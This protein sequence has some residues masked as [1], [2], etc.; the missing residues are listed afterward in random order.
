[1]ITVECTFL[2]LSLVKLVYRCG[3]DHL[4]LALTPDILFLQIFEEYEAMER[5]SQAVQN[6]QLPGVSDEQ[7]SE[8]QMGQ[9]E[10]DQELDQPVKK[11]ASTQWEE[12]VIDPSNFMRRSIACQ[13]NIKLKS[14]SVGIVVKPKTKNQTSNCRIKE[15]PE[16]PVT[17]CSSY[18]SSTPAKKR[19][20][21]FDSMDMDP[22]DTSY[23]PDLSDIEEYNAEITEST[24]VHEQTKYIVYKECL[25]ELLE[26]CPFCS[27]KTSLQEHKIGT[28]LAVSQECHHCLYKRKWHSQP[29][30]KNFPAGNLHLSA[31]ICFTGSSFTSIK[32]VANALHLEIIS[33]STYYEHVSRFLQPGIVWHWRMHQAALLQQMSSDIDICL[34]GDMRADSPGHSA[35]YGSYTLMNLK[36]NQVIDLQLIQS[37]EVGGSVHMEKEGLIRGLEKLEQA[38]IEVKAL[39]TDR[40]PQIQK[41]MREKK[42]EVKHYYD[43]WHV[44]KGVSRKLEALAKERNCDE[45]KPWIR[46]VV[47][48]LY[49][50]AATSEGGEQVVAKW[51]SIANHVQNIHTHDDEDYP[52]CLHESRTGENARKWLTPSTKACEK[53][54]DFVTNKRLLGNIKKLSPLHQTSTI[55]SFHSLVLKFAPKN[56]AFSYL[57][58]LCRLFLAALHFNEN[59]SRSQA[60]TKDGRPVYEIRFP[61]YKKGG[62]TVTPL[63]QE[64]TFNYIQELTKLTLEDIVM[65]TEKYQVKDIS[66]PPVL[67]SQFHRPDKAEAISMVMRRFNESDSSGPGNVQ[68]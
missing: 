14:R 27:R 4:D 55:E 63:K 19:K 59:A 21:D 49:Y 38:S 30:I 42:P 36:T 45:I 23:Q 65:D 20:L 1:M 22:H 68:L 28:F 47:N 40:H 33:E 9:P 44:A 11:D 24:P 51:K 67:C 7:H 56:V 13:A 62:F 53:L 34:G 6:D 46:S 48:H 15:K 17:S 31:A 12:I 57:G 61:K 60:K 54:C 41:Y 8:V 35:K 52:H 10:I 3:E 18:Y 64:P 25:W 26:N 32:K 37:N 58:M 39:V 66:I 2:L 29:M 16:S 43:V 5:T 50:C